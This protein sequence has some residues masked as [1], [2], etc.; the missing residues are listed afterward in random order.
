[1]AARSRSSSAAIS[2]CRATSAATRARCRLESAPAIEQ[3]G[4]TLRAQER[5]RVVLTRDLEPF[6]EQLAECGDRRLLTR[7]P[8]AAASAR[9]D[10]AAHDQLV[11]VAPEPALVELALE[12]GQCGGAEHG[13]DGRLLGALAYGAR[14]RTTAGEQRERSEHDRLA[15]SRLP[16]STLSPGANSS[17]ADSTIASSPIRSVSINARPSAASRA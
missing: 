16:V 4:V 3:L 1:V 13:L 6:R 7:H 10:R 15:R 2:R 17:S 14:G 8:R 9:R 5:L 11:R 12:L